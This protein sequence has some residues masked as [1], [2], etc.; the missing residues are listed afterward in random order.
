MARL[1]LK[2]AMADV[3]L[4]VDSLEGGIYAECIEHSESD[5]RLAPPGNC[6][7]MS[8]YPTFADA[9]DYAADHADTGRQDAL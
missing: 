9:A 1:I 6:S 3:A 4:T 2:G 5:G 7:W 8:H